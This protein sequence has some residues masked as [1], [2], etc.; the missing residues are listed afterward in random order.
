MATDRRLH[1]RAGER[2]AS[3][4]AELK[5]A[6]S[7]AKRAAS[8]GVTDSQETVRARR[9]VEDLGRAL[10]MAARGLDDAHGDWNAVDAEAGRIESRLETEASTLRG[11]LRA[12]ERAVDAI[13][14]ATRA[15]QRADRWSGDYGV[16]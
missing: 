10:A 11:E 5:E 14:E 13:E 4:R 6:E 8:D 12:A 1:A 15:V 16:S 7:L 9:A 3:A 2:I